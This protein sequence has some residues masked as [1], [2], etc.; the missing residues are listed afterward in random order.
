MTWAEQ[1]VHV[2]K[3]AEEDDLH[4]LV[5]ELADID[6]NLDYNQGSSG[7][8]LESRPDYKRTV[9]DFSRYRTRLAVASRRY[10]IY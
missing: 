1:P 2:D 5:M 6:I 3:P 9:W 4:C 10:L 8:A 7:P